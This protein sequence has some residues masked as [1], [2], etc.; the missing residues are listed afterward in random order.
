VNRPGRGGRA[1]WNGGDL[2][3]LIVIVAVGAVVCAV[4]WTGASGHAQLKDQKGWIAVGVAGFLVAV[5]GQS[6]WLRQGRRA[7]A[8]H[9]ARVMGDV[10]ALTPDVSHRSTPRAVSPEQHLVA[11]DGMRHFHRPDCPIATGRAWT[12]LPRRAHEATGRT[13]C[14][15]CQP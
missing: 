4:A 1:P 2:V 9:A 11:A 12:P 6:L 13:P 5:A 7:V 10:A 15:I 8:A 14:G 3:R